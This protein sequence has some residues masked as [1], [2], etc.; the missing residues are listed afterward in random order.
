MRGPKSLRSGTVL[1]RRRRRPNITG[2]AA[3]EYLDEITAWREQRDLFFKEHYATPL[4][5]EAIVSFAGLDYF[6]VDE[7]LMVRGSLSEAPE[8]SIS[9]DSSTG[10]VSQYPVAGI[11][12]VVLPGGMVSLVVLRGEED[13]AYIPFRDGTSGKESYGGGR[14]VSVQIGLEG[15]CIVDFNRAI[16][17]YCAYD[18][19]FSCPLPPPQ[20]WLSARIEAGERAFSLP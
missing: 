3:S 7:T 16:N 10:S 12:D 11:V 9:V 8:S 19:D 6:D 15:E 14:Y 20:N 1:P 4:S 17:P 18:S 5:D 2:M 13:E